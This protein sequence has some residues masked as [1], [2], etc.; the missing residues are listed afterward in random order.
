MEEPYPLGVQL[1]VEKI[2][3]SYISTR[4]GEAG[5]KTTLDWVFRGGEDDRDRRCR[6]FRSNRGVA[7]VR[8]DH[9]HPTGDQIS[10]HSRQAIE[11]ALQP[12]VLDRHVLAL[13]VAG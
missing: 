10:H 5:D 9:G 2:H 1:R 7:A 4:P 13:D 3:A 11:L 12:V 6:S 8:G